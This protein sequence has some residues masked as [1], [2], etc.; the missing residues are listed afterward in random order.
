M[1]ESVASLAF[2]RQAW[3]FSVRFLGIMTPIFRSGYL[4]RARLLSMISHSRHAPACAM[5]GQSRLQA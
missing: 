2:R 3:L 1:L 4:G 5:A